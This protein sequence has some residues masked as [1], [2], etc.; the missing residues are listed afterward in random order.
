MQHLSY[1]IGQFEKPAIIDDQ[2]IDAWIS[3]IESLPARFKKEVLGL[4]TEQLDAPYRPGGWTVRQLIHHV[5]DSH[6]NSYIRFHWALTEEAP[7]I[8]AYNEAA[9]AELSYLK[10]LDIK[11]SLDLLAIIHKRWVAL[12]RS[13][14]PT[15]LDKTFVHPENNE[16]YQLREVIGMYAWHGEHH[17]AHVKLVSEM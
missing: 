4:S 13:L 7:R 14:T 11:T 2:I 16:T 9:W 10:D 8:K 5:P 3:Q 1:P 12:L 17:L 15:D 6:I